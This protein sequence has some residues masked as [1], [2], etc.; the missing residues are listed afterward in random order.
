MA[1]SGSSPLPSRPEAADP[2]WS[3]R[4]AAEYL[5]VKTQTLAAWACLGRYSLPFI[6]VG[7][8]AKY[9]LSDLEKWIEQRA[10][11]GE[12]HER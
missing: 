11:G 5:G 10:V 7:R 9:R 8:L 6:R 2:L 3:R 12:V 4:E 1:G